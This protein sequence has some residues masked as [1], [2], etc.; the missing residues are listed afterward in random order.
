MAQK[1]TPKKVHRKSDE[2]RRED[3]IKV[4]VTSNERATLQG[5][6]DESGMSLSTWLR[7]VGLR[8]ARPS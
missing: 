2:E 8:A 7:H 3:L 4:R 5:A 1:K 6:A